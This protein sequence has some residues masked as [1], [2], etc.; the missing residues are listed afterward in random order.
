MLALFC[1]STRPPL[2]VCDSRWVGTNPNRTRAAM[3][4]YFR[5]LYRA[6]VLLARSADACGTSAAR[7][8]AVDVGRE[9]L[10]VAPCALRYT[11]VVQA[12][13]SGS[14]PLLQAAGDALVST[15]LDIDRLLSSHAGFALGARLRDARALGHNEAEADLMEWNQRSQV[16]PFNCRSSLPKCTL[17][18]S[19]DVPV[20]GCVVQRRGLRGGCRDGDTHVRCFFFSRGWVLWQFSL[21]VPWGAAGQAPYLVPDLAAPAGISDYATKQWGG[22]ERTIHAARFRTFLKHLKAAQPSGTLNMSRYVPHAS[23]CSLSTTTID[24]GGEKYFRRS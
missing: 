12:F 14:A 15:V 16:G 17:P 18:L 5:K 4:P 22:L 9:F 7:F 23:A 13:R 20:T 1:V 10:Q 21:W 19:P 24:C 8:D 2:C 11:C 6:W 3:E